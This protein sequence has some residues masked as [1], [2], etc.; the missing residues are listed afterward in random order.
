MPSIDPSRPS[1]HSLRLPDYDYSQPGTYFVT[2][3]TY[4]REPLFGEIKAGEMIQN[5]AGRIVWDIWRSLPNHFP[6]VGLEEA[7]VMPNHFHEIVAIVEAAAA[8][9]VRA[10]HEL[11][12]QVPEAE[13]NRLGRRRMLLPMMIGYFKMNSAKRINILLGSSGV[14]VWQRNYY[15]RIVRDNKA[16][17]SIRHYIQTNP[18]NWG[19][20]KENL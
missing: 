4:Q 17:E 14:P 20:D 1:R 11:P 7:V 3:V 5:D 8:V 12:L 9:P 13:A 19:A 6:N 16:Y 2:L 15:E 10:I 18:A